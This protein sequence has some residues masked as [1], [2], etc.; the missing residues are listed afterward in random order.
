MWYTEDDKL[1]GKK[2][3]QLWLSR[4]FKGERYM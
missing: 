1:Y 2:Q 4:S 3:N